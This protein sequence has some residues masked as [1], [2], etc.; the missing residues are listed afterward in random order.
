[1]LWPPH[2]TRSCAKAPSASQLQAPPRRRAVAS[3]R[4]HSH[5]LPAQSQTPPPLEPSLPCHPHATCLGKLGQAAC[6]LDDAVLGSE[7]LLHAVLQMLLVASEQR[8]N[9][10]N[11]L[12][13]EW[14]L[15]GGPGQCWPCEAGT[16]IDWSVLLRV[17][18]KNAPS[19]A[20]TRPGPAGCTTRTQH[21]SSQPNHT[22]DSTRYS[23]RSHQVPM[24][25]LSCF[26]GCRRE[27]G[28]RCALAGA[29]KAPGA[30]QAPGRGPGSARC[31]GRVQQSRVPG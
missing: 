29:P 18:D 22:D 3:T 1:M 23:P 4:T 13:P 24:F 27:P 14:E 11:A 5:R 9:V 20:K 28:A 26:R 8:V 12:H 31:Y 25:H 10:Q 7:V 17:E 2:P 21:L 19:S 15:I 16:W 30:C 6:M